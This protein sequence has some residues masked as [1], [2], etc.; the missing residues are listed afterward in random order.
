MKIRIDF[1]YDDRRI[2]SCKIPQE[3]L[4]HIYK[5]SEPS[6]PAQLRDQILHA[7]AHPIG[8][9][10]LSELI[11]GKKKIAVL[12]DDITRPTPV[13]KILPFILEELS[14][15]GVRSEQVTLVIALGSHRPMTE[16]EIQQRLGRQVARDYRVL[17]S[18]FDEPDH[19]V[20][21]GTSEDGV[22]IFIEEEVAK[23]DLKIGI[24]SIAPHGAVGWSGGAKIVYPG[25]AGRETVMRFHFAH[26]LTEENMTG[27]EDCSVRLKMEK[28]VDILGLDF[29]VNSILTPDDRVYRVVAGHYLRA[30]RRGVVFAKEMYLT[31]IREKADIVLS[32]SYAH[33][34]DFWQ[35]AKGIYGPDALVKDGGTLL[36]I[37]PCPEGTGPHPEFLP[38][39]GRDDNRDVLQGI[40][41]GKTKLPPDPISLA[42]AAMLAKM[43]RRVRCC[44]VSPGLSREDLA[45]AGYERFD[46]AQSGIDTLLK[47]Y[48]DGK[49][50]VVLRSDLAFEE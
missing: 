26:G 39:I 37:T 48:P 8:A 41:Q 50:A 46:D 38:R 10:M 4:S 25:V 5:M 6:K 45:T 19:L 31:Q 3:R 29:V 34:I 42:P 22:P 9:P 14:V 33:D 12:V 20:H 28:W 35:A 24:G 16:S 30:Q 2:S 49:V 27:K 36:L 47:R 32:A 40:L 1:A 13:D 11:R 21:L 44:V 43:R 15:H 17:N 23:A 7:F 18:R